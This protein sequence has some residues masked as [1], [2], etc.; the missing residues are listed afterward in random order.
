MTR[1]RVPH[2][3]EKDPVWEAVEDEIFNAFQRTL[4]LE[5]AWYALPYLSDRSAAPDHHGFGY[6]KPWGQGLG[7]PAHK[8][9]PA[10]HILAFWTTG[11]GWEYWVAKDTT[12]ATTGHGTL[13]KLARD[14]RRMEAIRAILQDLSLLDTRHRPTAIVMGPCAQSI[15]IFSGSDGYR[16][17]QRPSG[18]RLGHGPWPAPRTLLQKPHDTPHCVDNA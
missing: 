12:L 3:H 11:A 1:A 5:E 4:C 10:S 16:M 2:Y 7:L 6:S 14:A 17:S 9:I 18:N 13:R 15:Q 8:Q